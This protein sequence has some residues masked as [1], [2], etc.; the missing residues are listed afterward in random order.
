MHRAYSVEQTR[1]I[2]L[3]SEFNLTQP[4]IMGMGI[5]PD[6]QTV[7]FQLV[8]WNAFSN[9]EFKSDNFLQ[10]GRRFACETEIIPAF[11]LPEGSPLRH[12]GA[13]YGFCV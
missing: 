3:G 8:G 11:F 10:I 5:R 12:I 4:L 1:Q 9:G 6:E 2:S 7:P 13:V